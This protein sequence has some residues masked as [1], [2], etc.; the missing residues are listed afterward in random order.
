MPWQRLTILFTTA[1]RCG[2]R[3]PSLVAPMVPRPAVVVGDTTTVVAVAAMEIVVV[4]AVSLS[5]AHVQSAP[6]QCQCSVPCLSVGSVAI[7][8]AFGGFK[9]AH[10]ANRCVQS[11]FHRR[12][13]VII[14]LIPPPP[15]TTH[16]HTHIPC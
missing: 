7:Y 16:T 9:V 13:T 5:A 15:P 14:A 2:F 8:V 4:T 10:A 3:W 11:L 1:A 6:L 12:L